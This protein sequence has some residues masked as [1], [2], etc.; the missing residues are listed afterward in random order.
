MFR[1]KKGK[2]G[3]ICEIETPAGLAYVQYTHDN[4]DMGQLVRV[5]PGLFSVRPM[6]FDQFV[7]QKELYFIFYTLNYALRAG[8]TEVVSHQ[9]VPEW[10]QEDPVMRWAGARDQS[11]KALAWKIIK[12]S[13]GLTVEFHQRTPVIRTLTPE[14]E[15]LSI[16]VLRGHPAMVKELARGWTPER[17]EVLRLQDVAQADAEKAAQPTERNTPDKPIRHYLYFPKKTMADKAGEDLGSLGFSVEIRK[18]AGG[19]SWLALATK[20]LPETEEEAEEVSNKLEALAIKL[21]GEYDG[22]ELRVH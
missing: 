16:D 14:Q 5:L 22:C 10:A 3:D 18:G 19:V 15:R 13:D 12:A 2:I 1:K 9:P 7:K 4:S 8:Q 11:G 6:D 17:A 20:A 21:G